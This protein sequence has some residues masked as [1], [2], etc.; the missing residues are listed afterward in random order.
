LLLSIASGVFLCFHFAFWIESLSHTSVTSSVVLVTM[1]PIFLG[2]ASPLLLHERVSRHMILAI[3]IGL[4][5]VAIISAREMPSLAANRDVLFGNGLALAGA[6]MSSAYLLCGRRVRRSLSIVSYAYVTYTTAAVCLLLGV[7]LLRQPIV[8]YPSQ[9]YLFIFLLAFF[10]QLLGHSSFNWALKHVSAPVIGTIVL[11]EPI[12]A[13]ILAWFVLH[14]RP[15][16][17]ELVGGAVIL[18]AIALAATEIGI[19][20]EPA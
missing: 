7:L 20:T 16:P 11:G 13:S 2:I 1:N 18:A 9:T 6:I 15:A 10:P 8:G 12:G 4:A 17:I 5:G 14:E 19:D 3:A